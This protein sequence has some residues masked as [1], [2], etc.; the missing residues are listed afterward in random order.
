MP[1][2]GLRSIELHAAASRYASIKLPLL[3][4]TLDPRYVAADAARDALLQPVYLCFEEQGELWMHSLHLAAIA[5]TD[6]K[7]ASS[8]YGYGG[9]VAS[10]DDAAF[11]AAAWVAYCE[12]ME[13]Q[14][15]VVEYVRFHPVLGNERNYG[16]DVS[17][18]RPVVWMD[19]ARQ[20]VTADYAKRLRHSLKKAED[21][22][23]VYREFPLASHAGQFGAFYRDCMAGIGTDPFFLF[24][25]RYFQ[26]L[27]TSG[28]ARLGLCLRGENAD[29]PW[30][31]ACLFLDGPG[32]REY[33]LAA[34][35]PE[36]R[37]AGASAFAL[38]HAALAARASGIQRLYLG[39]G[40]D[41]HADN[42]LLFFKS[43][44]SALRLCYRTGGNVFDRKAYDEL[45]LLFPAA[46]AAH[47]E[48]PIFY[49]KV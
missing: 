41:V 28:L 34:T 3:P 12:W 35:G 10:C 4:A 30:L 38:H 2:E 8:P 7:D 32:V 24:G 45:K 11:L 29:G 33:H 15:V 43:A 46:W 13:R 36:G 26:G 31:S 1:G 47:P 23:L 44:Y 20:D 17:D 9:P 16:G 27:A 5:G 25:D 39:G 19:L 40:S 22:G 49:R 14:R 18:N 6:W 48:R 21:A 37:A 42:P